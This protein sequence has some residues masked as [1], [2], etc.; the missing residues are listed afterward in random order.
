MAR[1]P[2]SI[3]QF[4]RIQEDTAAWLAQPDWESDAQRQMMRAILNDD[5]SGIRAAFVAGV[6]VDGRPPRPRQEFFNGLGDIQNGTWLV[7][8]TAGHR[9]NAVDELL[10]L[11]ANP[12]QL[13]DKVDRVPASMRAFFDGDVA[14]AQVYLRHLPE[15]NAASPQ[16]VEG[17]TPL[18]YVLTHMPERA[19]T[20]PAH[21]ARLELMEMLLARGGD[22]SKRAAGRVLEGAVTSLPVSQ[23]DRLESVGIRLEEA[24]QETRQKMLA[25]VLLLADVFD[26]RAEDRVSGWFDALAKLGTPIPADPQVAQRSEQIRLRYAKV[27][28]E[29]FPSMMPAPASALDPNRPRATY[30]VPTFSVKP[31][32]P[33]LPRPGEPEPTP[34]TRVRRRQP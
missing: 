2:S 4:A 1:T 26:R 24:S 12:D 20:D 23:L 22:F 7:R 8:A 13:V 21:A 11:G 28:S 30:E 3:S 27:L 15:T 9:P 14:V 29:A 25:R 17:D 33:P 16:S 19:F 31:G 5:A 34:V 6:P 32:T 10:A 18:S